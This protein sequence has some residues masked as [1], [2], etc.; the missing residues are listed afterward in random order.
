VQDW[1]SKVIRVGLPMTMLTKMWVSSL[2]NRILTRQWKELNMFEGN[3]CNYSRPMWKLASYIMATKVLRT[4]SWVLMCLLPWTQ[5]KKW[6][7]IVSMGCV[8]MHQRIPI[9][10]GW[11]NLNHIR[12]TMEKTREINWKL[13]KISWI[14]NMIEFG[15]DELQISRWRTCWKGYMVQM[16]QDG[17]LKSNHLLPNEL[18]K[19]KK[20]CVN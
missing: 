7:P 8:H 6:I 2:V 10:E 19:R 18:F 5:R 14:V 11:G 13:K 17:I 20:T 1:G 9:I 16:F 4:T 12:T 15:H 3:T